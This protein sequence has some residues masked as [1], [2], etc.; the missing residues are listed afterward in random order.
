MDT[1]GAVCNK[2]SLQGGHYI[3]EAVCHGKSSVEYCMEVVLTTGKNLTGV[4][5][6]FA[7]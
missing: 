1:D 4:A 5:V 2:S 3:S 7:T 6:Q